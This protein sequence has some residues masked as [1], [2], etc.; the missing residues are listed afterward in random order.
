MAGQNGHGPA[1]EEIAQR[2]YEIY[3]QRGAAEGTALTDW[4]QAERELSERYHG[5]PAAVAT[6][7]K[8]KKGSASASGSRR[9]A[10]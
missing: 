4:L 10:G 7:S 5:E 8:S 1:Y 6:V 2:A 3:L 9:R